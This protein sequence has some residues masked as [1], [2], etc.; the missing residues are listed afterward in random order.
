MQWIVTLA[1]AIALVAEEGT[2]LVVG[3]AQKIPET[4]LSFLCDIGWNYSWALWL[5]SKPGVMEFIILPEKQTPDL[6]TVCPW[7]TIIDSVFSPSANEGFNIYV[8]VF[9]SFVA[10]SLLHPGNT[11]KMFLFCFVNYDLVNN[12]AKR[13]LLSLWLSRWL[14]IHEWP[15][16][17]RNWK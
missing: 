13:L 16:Y 3:G 5:L 6:L 8:R 1:E 12:T 11:C 14:T 4:G 10:M 9:L 17:Y 15:G 2:G 7:H